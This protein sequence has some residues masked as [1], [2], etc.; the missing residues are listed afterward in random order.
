M[1]GQNVTWTPY[2]GSFGAWSKATAPAASG[3][4]TG[5]QAARWA[6]LQEQA[7]QKKAA[8]KARRR[9]RR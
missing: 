3:T 7:E 8:R 6:F 2:S 9:G 1:A 4:Y 5:E